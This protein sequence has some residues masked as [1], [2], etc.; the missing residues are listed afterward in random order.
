MTL[1]DYQSGQSDGDRKSKI[2]ILI[3]VGITDFIESL[4]LVSQKPPKA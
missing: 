4:M 3:K 1:I 2:P